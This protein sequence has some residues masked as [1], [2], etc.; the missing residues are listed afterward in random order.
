MHWISEF[1]A[2]GRV[3][4]SFFSFKFNWSLHQLLELICRLVLF[5]RSLSIAN[6]G[7]RCSVRPG[8]KRLG[9][10]LTN[11]GSGPNVGSNT[12]A[13][14]S[15]ERYHSHTLSSQDG[16]CPMSSSCE[17]KLLIHLE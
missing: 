3:S 5:Y 7:I 4:L 9:P 11:T 16:K 17:A 1:Q 2:F 8:G 10:R 14:I 13:I 15:V 6:L 12:S